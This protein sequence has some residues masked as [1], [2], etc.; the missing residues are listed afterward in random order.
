MKKNSKIYIA[1][2][3]GL[4]GKLL[5]G[6]LQGS[7]YDN[8]IYKTFKELDLRR[9]EDV[10]EFFEKEKP[11]YVFMAAA[12]TGGILANNTYRGEFIYDNIMIS[13]NVIN[14][15]YMYGVKKLLNIGS[16]CVY[17]KSA[18]QPLREEYLLTDTLEPTIEP[19]AIAK[20]S[21]I[22]LCKY[23]N[24]QHGTNFISAIPINLY[25]PGD[26]FDLETGHVVPSLI[27]KFYLAKLLSER[28]YS[29]IVKDLKKNGNYSNQ[30]ISSPDIE[31]IISDLA[32]Y[33]IFSDSVA[34]WGTGN[35]YREF[36]YAEDLVE[37]LLFLMKNCD[38]EQVG[39]IVNIGTGHDMRIK[40][41]AEIIKSVVGFTGE[42]SFDTSK[43][44]GPPRKLMETEKLNSIGWTA[45]TT[46][47]EG[48]NKTYA[49]YKK[50]D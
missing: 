42:I 25:G 31:M 3:K 35:S 28:K 40:K 7:G 47:E 20:I 29:N 44:E 11:E 22:K 49:W 24:E 50:R 39:E 13:A 5:I 30:N 48:I 34:I 16:A 17:P 14:S 6:K 19:Y 38:F 18:D 41:V 45:K 32:R 23:Y 37:A 43:P 27:R 1:G 10:E 8:L 21:A 26:K 9:Q 15:A 4:V 46:L 33:G 12:K 36:L 2:H